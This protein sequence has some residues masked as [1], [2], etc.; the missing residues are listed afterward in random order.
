MGSRYRRGA[1]R[2]GETTDV[3]PR[4]QTAM[5]DR[6]SQRFAVGR[7][8]RAGLARRVPRRELGVRTAISEAAS[9][10]DV[11]QRE[12]RYRR[13]LATGDAIA[14]VVSLVVVLVLGL[15][16]DLRPLGATLAVVSLVAANKLSGLYDRDDIVLHRSTLDEVPRLVQISGLF[17]LIAWLL[18]G[19]LT[20]AFLHQ[21]NILFLWATVFAALVTARSVARHGAAR[22]STTERC[23]VLGDAEVARRIQIKIR[24]SRVKADVVHAMP[25]TADAQSEH[26]RDQAAFCELIRLHDVQRVIIAPAGS[27]SGPT[28]EMVRMAKAAGLRVSLLP[29]LLEVVGSSVEFDELDGLTMLGIRRFGL[30]RSSRAVKRGLDVVGVS[31]GLFAVA[32][33]L[34]LI[35]VAIRLDSRGPVFFR[36]TRVGRDGR[37]FQMIKFRT[38]VPEAEALRPGLEALNEGAEGFFKIADDPRVT[39]MGRLLRRTSLDELPQLFNVLIGEMSLVGPRPLVEEEDARILGFDR[40]RLHLTPGMTG[41]WQIL[42]S[43]RIPIDEMM[44]IDYL[45]VAN[46]SMWTDIKILLRTAVH[47]FMRKGM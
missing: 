21:I 45:Y 37:R 27:W 2:L 43:A 8:L 39:R 6:N 18:H 38:M 14:A 34:A 19:A 15:G 31:L 40:G 13:W 41:H 23:L 20:S 29:S 10:A 4:P 36:Q 17:A 7:P 9:V 3:G 33:L 5:S 35:A 12:G 26:L 11:A 32:P 42:G 47:V 24:D 44:S 25:M 16:A 22:F 28:L 1:G 30:T 46:W